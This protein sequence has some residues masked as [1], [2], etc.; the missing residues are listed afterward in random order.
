MSLPP[1]RREGRPLV[2]WPFLIVM[3]LVLSGVAISLHPDV[4]G[5]R[6]WTSS[7]ESDAVSLAYLELEVNRR[8]TVVPLR[9]AYVRQLMGVGQLDRA[10]EA[11]APLVVEERL[12]DDAWDLILEVERERVRAALGD[13]R[14]RRAE[15]LARLLETA[16]QR[17]LSDD[18]KLAYAE[19]A[20]EIGRPDLAARLVEK[21]KLADEVR[22]TRAARYW[23][24]AEDPSAAADRWLELAER[25]RGGRGRPEVLEST[26]AALRRA[27]RADEG[28]T[29]T[30]LWIAQHP[31]PEA[32]ELAVQLELEL[33]DIERALST[34]ER[35]LRERPEDPEVLRR[36]VGLALAVSRPDEGLVAARRLMSVEPGRRENRELR[37]RVEE[38]SG[39][40][41]AA[42]RLW[43]GLT[44]G[45]TPR[46]RRRAIEEAERLARGL[47]DQQVLLQ[48]LSARLDRGDDRLEV[49]E[50]IVYLAESVGE[51]EQARL[52]LLRA[53]RR[54]GAPKRVWLRLARL[55]ARMGLLA[56][57]VERWQIL[58]ARFGTDL[59]EA[60][61]RAGVAWR[62]LGPDAAL[63]VLRGR[64]LATLNGPALELL[65]D[66]AWQI[67]DRDLGLAA[68]LRLVDRGARPHQISRLIQLL[69]SRGQEAQALEVA[70]AG[71]RATDD[72]ELLLSA[73][74]LA[75]RSAPE[76]E[77]EV[78]GVSSEA[79]AASEGRPAFWRLRAR[80][81]SLQGRREA[82]KL[83][84][85]SALRLDGGSVQ[86][87]ADLLWLLLD[88]RD[89][90]LETWYGRI[91][92]RARSQP[93]LWA[94]LAASAVA[95]GR[96]REALRWYALKAGQSPDGWRFWLDY[97]DALQRVGRRDAALRMRRFAL[98]KIPEVSDDLAHLLVGAGVLPEAELQLRARRLVDD[99]RAPRAARRA[100]AR[101][102]V[103]TDGDERVLGFSAAPTRTLTT[104]LHEAELGLALALDDHRAVG[105][106]M[107]VPRE[108]LDPALVAQGHAYLGHY[109]DALAAA[110]VSRVDG[111][112]GVARATLAA[113][114]EAESRAHPRELRAR[115]RY[116][117]WGDLEALGFSV[118]GVY[119]RGAWAVLFDAGHRRFDDVPGTALGV[120]VSS[121]T[122]LGIGGR[123]AWSEGWLEA[124]IGAHLQQQ[125]VLQAELRFQ[126][127]LNRKLN[128]LA[129]VG[130]GD[131]VGETPS[132][133]TLGV[134]DRAQVQLSGV[135]PVRTQWS[136]G[137]DGEHHRARDGRTFGLGGVLR[138]QVSKGWRRH[139]RQWEV[140]GSGQL[141]LRETNEVFEGELAALA[142]RGLRPEDVLPTR[143]AS[144]GVGARLR[145][146]AMDLVPTPRRRLRYLVDVWGGWQWPRNAPAFRVEAGVGHRLF[147]PDEI[148]ARG[149]VGNVVGG[150]D[151]VQAGVQ[152]EY[153]L[154]LEP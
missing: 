128:V 8:P 12:D 114:L 103:T 138:A 152:L 102:L 60:V 132:L 25:E 58:D 118:D 105:R 123:R 7:A 30:R 78:L 139:G 107:S 134:R 49:L 52:V 140:Y 143:F 48:V 27:D 126:H 74:E 37:A 84:L 3:G 21:T 110:L 66:L 47:G 75:A 86:S 147:G 43:W 116:E 94:P 35:L 104:R 72:P 65:A 9:V 22:L 24:E 91:R 5:V 83:A 137:L 23:A 154:R 109:G 67:G 81:A 38:W 61:E 122:W 120:P 11:A 101:Q 50:Q 32:L 149:F 20:S 88:L 135:G 36:H 45:G 113:Y 10:S 133:L 40:P 119:S 59:D 96:D 98:R 53:T 14:R 82:A 6:T 29:L 144:A 93:L 151:G 46:A 15:Y 124:R 95:L 148:S 26:V 106:L 131:V 130:V 127:A 55:E 141:T 117:R 121:D 44:R 112:G 4:L 13:E 80:I 150:Q 31:S 73:L 41:E 99:E 142:A 145:Q 76:R 34:S 100:A 92:R 1:S 16:T 68:H 69:R 89:D 129:R 56:G 77:T 97:A 54:P 153:R 62:V 18:R 146:G 87:K 111:R 63:D 70:L 33:G 90:E 57:A 51:P 39:R 108:D 17:D 28:L 136:V 19:L 71:L 2:G 125:A 115:T 79:V 42:L 64:P 85:Q